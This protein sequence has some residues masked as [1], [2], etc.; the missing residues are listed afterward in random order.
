MASVEE[1]CRYA[2]AFHQRHGRIILTMSPPNPSFGRPVEVSGIGLP[3]GEYSLLLASP[4]LNAGSIEIAIPTVAAD[5]KL[6]V[7]FAMP[8]YTLSEYDPATQS[9]GATGP[10]CAVIVAWNRVEP[11]DSRSYMTV[12]FVIP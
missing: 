6:S 8:A 1:R 7:A 11:P 3:P 4:I 10:R 5:G 2:Q 9:W 12:P